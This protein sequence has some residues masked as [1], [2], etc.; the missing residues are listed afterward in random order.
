M[1]R[2]HAAQRAAATDLV[3][4]ARVSRAGERVL[5]IANFSLPDKSQS[6]RRRKP[7]ANR[8]TGMNDMAG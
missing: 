5:A 7:S 8:A 3:E 6:P 4:L 2:A 1:R